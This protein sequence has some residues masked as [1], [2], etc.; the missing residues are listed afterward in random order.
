MSD[1]ANGTFSSTG[2]SEEIAVYDYFNVEVI[3]SSTGSVDLQRKLHGNDEFRTVETITESLSKVGFEPER[4]ATYR[5]KCNS[6]DGTID[7]RISH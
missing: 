7:Y 2:T 3:F 6:I 1:I 4:Q 5:L